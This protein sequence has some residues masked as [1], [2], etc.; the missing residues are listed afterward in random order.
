MATRI[1]SGHCVSSYRRALAH[2]RAR[3][4]ALQQLIQP[5]VTDTRHSHGLH[6]RVRT[7]SAD[8][9]LRVCGD[10]YLAVPL[11]AG[12][13][14]F[15][16]GDVTGHGLA[17][18]GAMVELRYAMSAYACEG[19]PPAVVLSRLD[20]L[21][22]K[23][24]QHVMASAVIVHYS[25]ADAGLS[26][27]SAGHPPILLAHDGGVSVLPNPGGALLGSGLT[28]SYAQAGIRLRHGERVICY[29]DGMLGRG[30]PD[31]G[32]MTLAGQFRDA[33]RRPGSPMDHLDWPTGRDRSDDASVLV[34]ERV[35]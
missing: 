24:H 20:R 31:E 8:S 33:H 30:S 11:E 25:P 4:R 32:I 1:E 7:V 13:L 22:T 6:V 35:A 19:M 17:A 23:H 29:T 15:A 14:V 5:A 18:A 10:W 27:A 28:S 3:T 26:W 9:D 21:M 12:G 34:A 16:V 2:E